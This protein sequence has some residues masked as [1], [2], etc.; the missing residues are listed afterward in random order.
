MAFIL[1]MVF[2]W[3]I[4]LMLLWI[5]KIIFSISI[6]LVLCLIWAGGFENNVNDLKKTES[7]LSYNEKEVHLS[8]MISYQ[9]IELKSLY[10]VVLSNSQ[11]IFF[12]CFVKSFSLT[13]AHFISQ[14]TYLKQPWREW[15]FNKLWYFARNNI[16]W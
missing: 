10:N 14:L 1:V 11:Y 12:I 6:I 13:T 7:Q 16:T 4:N 15:Y 8:N 3:K 9:F 2:Q 5:H